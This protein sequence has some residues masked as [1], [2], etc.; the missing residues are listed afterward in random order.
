MYNEKVG[1]LNVPRK[2]LREVHTKM[3]KT[4]MFSIALLS[5]KYEDSAYG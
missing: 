1:K 4:D 5:I 2:K 3:S